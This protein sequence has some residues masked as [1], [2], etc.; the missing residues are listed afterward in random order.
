ME[1]YETVI[2][3]AGPAGLK[4]AET[5]A[6]AGKEVLVLEKNEVIGPKVCAGGLTINCI[7]SGIPEKILQR[8]FKKVKI[9]TPH[10]D[11]EIKLEKPFVAT[12]NRKDLGRWMTKEAKMQGAEI[13]TDSLVT[14]IDKNIL[15]INNEKKIKYKYL[16]G[17]DGSNSIVRK[18]LKIKKENVLEA[19]QYITP[20]K[21][22]DMEVFIDPDRFGP[23]YLWIFPHKNVTSI[24]TGGDLSRKLKKPILGIK[25]SQIRKNFDTWCNNHFDTKESQFE[26]YTINYDYRGHHFGNKYLIGDAAGFASGL[27]GEGI[28]FGIK[29]GEDV[30]KTIMD[31]K[32]DEPNIK[33]ILKTKKIQEKILRTLEISKT[34]TCLEYDF[35]NLFF[36]IKMVDQ[37]L[38]K[39][40]D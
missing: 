10:E 32:Y 3:G 39:M 36:K 38:V 7:N 37:K 33:H 17:A 29:S 1:S 26:A 23:A 21:F 24:G 20:K 25:L 35:L 19:F 11:T 30:A 8:K 9:H 5:L 4:C 18:H 13:R 14:K 12:V 28:Y 6:K 16:V 22:R 2:V 27:T 15:T 34:R 31:P 40:I